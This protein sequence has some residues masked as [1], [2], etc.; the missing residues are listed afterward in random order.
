MMVSEQENDDDEEEDGMD[1]QRA[2][3]KMDKWM[4]EWRWWLRHRLK[5]LPQKNEKIPLTLSDFREKTTM[6]K[7][8]LE[9]TRDK[10]TNAFNSLLFSIVLL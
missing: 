7:T 4:N 2:K 3:E 5:Q 6:K 10:W 8:T 9:R 1:A